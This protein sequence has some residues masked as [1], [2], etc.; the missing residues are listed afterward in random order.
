MNI[1]ITGA[2]GQVGQTYQMTPDF[3]ENIFFFATRDEV[4]ILD[5]KKLDNFFKDNEVDYVINLAAYTNVEKA[6]D[7]NGIAYEVNCIG[8]RN[9]AAVCEKYGAGLIHISTDYVFD[10]K[11]E[12]AYTE[13]DKTAPINQYGK[14][15]LAGEVE[16]AKN[17]SRYVIIRTSWVYSNYGSN[18]YLKMYDI[19]QK[20]SEINV[21]DDQHGSP[22]SAN[23]LCKAIDAVLQTGITPENSGVYHFSGKGKTTW[24]D[25]AAE[26]FS[27]AYV[28]VD[29]LP[30]T[31][32]FY[33]TKAERPKNSY[34]S[35][36]KFSATFGYYSKHWK[37]A[38]ADI[39][40]ERKNFP[41]KVGFRSIIKDTE[42]V[43]VS[44]DWSKEEVTLVNTA[45][46]ITTIT[47]SF[48][49]VFVQHR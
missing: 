25:F 16:V 13:D 41:I 23:E 28:P 17:C 2:A 36:E 9:L 49:D 42:Y 22:T 10:G 18:F 12:L 39:V 32:T 21:V 5:F 15:K 33:P 19:A 14:T 47:L 8:P 4:D 44:V 20:S 26:I 46:M 3:S 1:L 29:V 48:S 37:L 27:Q 38:L 6:E 24:K 35:S 43:I 31:S 40:S 7:E 30:V 45:D 11:K 34:M